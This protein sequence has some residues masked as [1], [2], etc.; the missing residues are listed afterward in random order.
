MEVMQYAV[1]FSSVR[2]WFV[3]LYDEVDREF[4]RIS[5]EF[6]PDFQEA[7]AAMTQGTWTPA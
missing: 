5:D 6:Y 1:L 7:L 4:S 2:G 3:A